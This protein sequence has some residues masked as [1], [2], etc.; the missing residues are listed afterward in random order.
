MTLFG[1]GSEPLLANRCA[2]EMHAFGRRGGL[3]QGTPRHKAMTQRVRR[4]FTASD[5]TCKTPTL[6]SHP[7]QASV[8]LCP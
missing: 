5:N 8:M 4:A 1:G 3:P 2:E 6:S 7:M